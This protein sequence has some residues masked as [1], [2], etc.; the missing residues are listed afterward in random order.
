VNRVP[1]IDT[2]KNKAV[3]D[4]DPLVR[5]TAKTLF[6]FREKLI[7]AELK[8]LGFLLIAAAPRAAAE[9]PGA[10]HGVVSAIQHAFDPRRRIVDFLRI[11]SADRRLCERK[12]QKQ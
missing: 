3:R 2:I 8:S 7:V 5:A 12:T 9:L 1:I 11:V 10:N 4:H 6:Q